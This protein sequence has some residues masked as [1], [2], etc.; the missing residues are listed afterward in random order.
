MLVIYFL[1]NDY[2]AKANE[3][4]KKINYHSR[5]KHITT[6]ELNKLTAENFAARLA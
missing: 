2:D 3:I 6:L 1:K 4:E 5:D